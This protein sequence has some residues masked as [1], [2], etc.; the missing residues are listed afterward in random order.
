MTDKK[1]LWL[2]TG[3]TFS[4]PPEE[5]ALS[6]DA[7][8]AQAERML[9]FCGMEGRADVRVIMNRDSSNI[10]P[11]DWE[12]LAREINAAFG[13]YGG[14]VITHGTDTLSYTAAALSA[15]LKDPP[16]PVVLTGSQ[17]PFFAENSDA[18]QNLKDAF[19]VAESGIR[20]VA[21]VFCGR[22]FFGCDLYK[23]D[24]EAFDAF[25]SRRG[26]LGR[27][28]DGKAEFFIQKVKGKYRYLPNLCR[29]VSL[30]K[31]SPVFDPQII[32][33][34]TEKGCQGIVLECYGSGGIPSFVL[35]HIRAAA[36]KGVKFVAVS[37]CTAGRVELS[38][39]AVG[40]NA[41]AAGVVG[42]GNIGA[43]QALADLMTEI[44]F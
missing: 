39:Y 26:E 38:R 31:I 19:C 40:A 20:E 22:V 36:E 6:P 18:P 28:K 16:A 27:V 17:L 41:A 23:A 21:A 32:D 25:R 3:G 44:N 9:K 7:S 29:K 34:L 43:A 8:T 5:K 1:L 2:M 13:V 14:V 4:C 30:L 10:C 15:M 24:S 33:M 42:G 37:E 11:A 35:E 12:T